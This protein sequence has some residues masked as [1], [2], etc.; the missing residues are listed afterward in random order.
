MFCVDGLDFADETAL[1]APNISC[2]YAHVALLYSLLAQAGLLDSNRDGPAGGVLISCGVRCRQ[3]SARTGDDCSS[4]SR[5]RCRAYPS[6]PFVRFG[7]GHV[8]AAFAHVNEPEGVGNL[9]GCEQVQGLV[10]LGGFGHWGEDTSRR[11]L[12]GRTLGCG[13]DFLEPGNDAARIN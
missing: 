3:A 2:E 4:S 6:P 12:C 11:D 13:M 5:N 1:A 10:H 9:V 8:L 7:L